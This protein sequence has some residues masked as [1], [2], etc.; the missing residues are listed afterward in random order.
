MARGGAHACT[1]GGRAPRPPR[2]CAFFPTLTSLD[3]PVIFCI[4][5]SIIGSLGGIGFA[6]PPMVR[7]SRCELL[8]PNQA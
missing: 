1:L 4:S 5:A 7:G 2:P 3:A 6:M 8:S